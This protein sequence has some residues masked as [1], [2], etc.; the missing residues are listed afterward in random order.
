MDV[1]KPMVL[2]VSTNNTPG[3]Q[4][5]AKSLE[6]FGYDHR[7]LGLGDKW[8]GFVTKMT[9]YRDS[10]KELEPDK[11]VVL[12]DSSDALAVRPC[13]GL[14]D[15]YFSFKKE[16]VCGAEFL[17][18]ANGGR[19]GKWHALQLQTSG[20]RTDD[21][22]LRY[23]NSG[24]M[25]GRAKYLLG[26]LEFCLKNGYKDDQLGLAAWANRHPEKF[27]LDQWNVVAQNM[28]TLNYDQRARPFFKHFCG[29]PIA[30]YIQDRYNRTAKDVL[31]KD[32][33]TI[34]LYIIRT[35]L[36]LLLLILIGVCL[37]MA[38]RGYKRLD[39]K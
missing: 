7:V 30:M 9:L 6:R 27:H 36:K 25:I 14:T 3:L 17:A 8:R 21:H 34:P 10:L 38:F 11:V 1:V 15:A 13:D 4:N 5:L 37:A 24:V 33:M 12:I 22:H 19:V 39:Y 29:M 23:A 35:D 26:M 2:T 20:K 28:N 32:A 16:I 18:F 31:A